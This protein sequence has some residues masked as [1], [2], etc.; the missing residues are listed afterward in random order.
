MKTY[1]ENLADQLRLTI[2]HAPETDR[3]MLA[4]MLE[5]YAQ[6]YPRLY[7]SLRNGRAP[8]LLCWLF[9]AMVEGSEARP[10]D[11]LAPL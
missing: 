2:E 10:V 7:K 1:S 5:S 8:T 11:S 4:E 9:D 3:F 6:K